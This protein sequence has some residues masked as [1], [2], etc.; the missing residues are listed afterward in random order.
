MTLLF[1]RAM[2]EED[3]SLIQN[4][5]DHW[6]LLKLPLDKPAIQMVGNALHIVMTPIHSMNKDIAKLE[7]EVLLER[8]SAVNRTLQRAKSDT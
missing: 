2:L 4:H 1:R 5:K 6:K 7:R 3:L 8:S